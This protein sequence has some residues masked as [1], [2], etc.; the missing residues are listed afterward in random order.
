MCVW[1]LAGFV[2]D[3]AVCDA[4]EGGLCAEGDTK[5]KV[6]YQTV[7]VIPVLSLYFFAELFLKPSGMQ[8][9]KAPQRM[10]AI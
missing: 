6:K 7:K 4:T 5:I 8:R 1:F 2:R 9:R 3:D 10:F